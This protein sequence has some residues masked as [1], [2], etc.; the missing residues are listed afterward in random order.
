MLLLTPNEPYSPNST[1]HWDIPLHSKSQKNRP[2][3]SFW[4]SGDQEQKFQKYLNDLG[5]W[6]TF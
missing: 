2:E 6:D 3:P 5:A 1:L 4:Y